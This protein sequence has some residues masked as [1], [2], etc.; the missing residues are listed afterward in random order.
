LKAAWVNLRAVLRIGRLEAQIDF[1]P[2]KGNG[3]RDSHPWHV[4]LRAMRGDHVRGVFSPLAICFDT[5]A[6]ARTAALKWV[7]RRGAR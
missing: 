6:K 1:R 7:E 4:S 5:E 2:K 3:H